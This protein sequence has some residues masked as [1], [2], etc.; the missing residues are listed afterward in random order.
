M[1]H[2]CAVTHVVGF[3]LDSLEDFQGVCCKRQIML[4]EFSPK[5]TIIVYGD[6]GA[7]AELLPHWVSF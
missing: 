2:S 1:M 5:V 6:F 7:K 4:L 3:K